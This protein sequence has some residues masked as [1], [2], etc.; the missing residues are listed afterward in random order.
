[1]RHVI[2]SPPIHKR[3]RHAKNL[4][5]DGK[6]KK[7][8]GFEGENIREIGRQQPESNFG[9]RKDTRVSTTTEKWEGERIAHSA[10]IV[11]NA[12]KIP[13]TAPEAPNELE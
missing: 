3:H 2:D 5:C 4:E 10:L 1:M 6:D 9:A 8:A 7:R 11:Q 13:I 12:A